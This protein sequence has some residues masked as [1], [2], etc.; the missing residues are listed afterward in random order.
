M[1]DPTDVCDTATVY[2]ITDMGATGGPGRF[3]H[4]KMLGSRRE[5]DFRHDYFDRPIFHQHPA[6]R[7]PSSPGDPYCFTETRPE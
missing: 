6:S 4:A 7:R 5:R 1:E 3:V 2:V